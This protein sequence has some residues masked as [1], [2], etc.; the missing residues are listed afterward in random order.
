MKFLKATFVLLLFFFAA[1]AQEQPGYYRTQLGNVDVYAISDGTIPIHLPGLLNETS[2]GEV[3]RLMHSNFLDTVLENSVTGFLIHTKDQLILV[4][5]GCGAFFGPTVGKLKQHLQAAGFRAEDVTAVLLTHLHIDHVGGLLD[6]DKMA[7]PNAT[8]YVSKPEADFW[9]NPTNKATANKRAEP[10]FDMAQAAVK[11]YQQ[12][13]K[14]KTFEPGAQ[15][16]DGI[17][18]VST[19]GH[20]PG[21]SAYLLQS[22]GQQMLFIGDIVHVAAVQFTDAAVTINFDVD[23][24]QA[25]AT[26]R[27]EF[28]EIVAKKYWVAAPHLPFPG[29]GHVKA[30]GAEYQY[31][32]ANYTNIFADR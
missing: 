7:F 11:L 32:P 14:I 10:F 17:T 23:L 19:P 4:D 1:N 26:R 30:A 18:A 20:T 12:A 16:F 28:N 8:V 13:G 25:A 6:D 29:I 2:P 5:V 21:Q 27:K 9:L 3:E 22:A 24:K 15:L 31:V